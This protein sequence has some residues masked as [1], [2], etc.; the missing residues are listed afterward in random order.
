M[1]E[2]KRNTDTDRRN[3]DRRKADNVAYS[4]P[5]RRAHVRRTVNDRRAD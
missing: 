3:D 4:G 2:D 5:E 1:G